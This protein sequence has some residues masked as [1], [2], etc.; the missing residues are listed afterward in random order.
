MIVPHSSELFERSRRRVNVGLLL[1]AGLLIA[2]WVTWWSDR[3]L[4]ASRTTSPYYTFE[5]A[6][7]LADA[8]LLSA[9]VTAAVQLRRRRPSAFPWLIA[10]GGAGLYLLGMDL[11]YDLGHGIYGSDGGGVIE[12]A[13]DLLI[14]GASIGVLTWAWRY[15][16]LLLN[17]SAAQASTD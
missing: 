4:I 12:L 13:I 1:A 5:D 15:R 9:I 11:F 17:D 16:T 10:A 7:Q 6:F 8:W 3:S 14:A 2:Y